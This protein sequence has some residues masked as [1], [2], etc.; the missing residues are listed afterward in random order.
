MILDACRYLEGRTIGYI[1][2][3]HEQESHKIILKNTTKI[4]LRGISSQITP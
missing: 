2:S 3:P 1:P 4:A